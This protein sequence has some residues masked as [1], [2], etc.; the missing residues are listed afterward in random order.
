MVLLVLKDADKVFFS[1]YSFE[2]SRRGFLHL[3]RVCKVQITVKAVCG[4]ARSGIANLASLWLQGASLFL[5]QCPGVISRPRPSGVPSRT[6]RGALCQMVQVPDAW[7][8][9]T[10]LEKKTHL[11]KHN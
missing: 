5:L 2:V 9:R 6:R 3:D 8:P 10:S 4:E 1:L 7:I 11:G